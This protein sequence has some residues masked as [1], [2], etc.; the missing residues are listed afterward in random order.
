[1]VANGWSRVA[2][3]VVAILLSTVVVSAGAAG[4]DAR[5][6]KASWPLVHV[7]DPIANYLMGEVLEKASGLLA[8]PGCG[9]VLT[10]FSDQHG[11]P[12]A[13]RLVTLDV[14]IRTYASMIV[15]IDD[16]RHPHCASG[17]IA[18][19]EPGGRV[20][21]L[22]VDRLKEAWSRDRTFTLAVVIH[23]LLHTLGLGE[24]P[25]TSK[26]ITTQVLARC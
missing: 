23:E 3:S 18:F 19:T 13:A 14:D 22:C 9:S 4:Q 6:S 5:N 7:P 16:S 12:L 11:K 2:I 8:E 21:R 24:N 15:F 26:E 10:D 17:A 20:V 25:P 1:M